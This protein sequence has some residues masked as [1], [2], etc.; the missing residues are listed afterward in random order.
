MKII[1][2]G[3]NYSEH[4]KELSNATPESPVLFLKP[5]TALVN[6]EFPMV[7]P[8]FTQNLQY[9][10]ELVVRI[11]RAGKC[12]QAQFASKYYDKIALGIDFTARDLQQELKSKGL[13]WEKSKAFDNSALVSDF[14]DVSTFKDLQNISFSLKQ[15]QKKVQKGNSSEMLW[16]INEL[17]AYISEYFT[18]KTGDLIFTGTPAGVGKIQSEDYLQGF[19][20]DKEVFSV[21]FL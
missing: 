19:I 5:D 21:R 10:T 17:I 7:I 4:I 18:L 2:V 20:E 12:I 15:N 9:E 14:F 13:P 6:K 3:R 1:C 11:N 16:K 8:E